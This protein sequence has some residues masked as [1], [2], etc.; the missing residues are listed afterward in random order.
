MRQEHSHTPLVSNELCDGIRPPRGGGRV[1][2][3]SNQMRYTRYACATWSKALGTTLGLILFFAC[4]ATA[5]DFR[6]KLTVTVND[7]SGLA[8]PGA[9]LELTNANSGELSSV[10]T[11]ETGAYSFLF[12][13][14]GSYNLKVSAAGFK[15]T[16]RD[17]IVLQSYQAS[18][19]EIRM[20]VGGV[21]D[22]VT[23]TDEG[24]LL[25]TETASRGMNVDSRL[26][27]DL[28]V[29]N[30]NAMMLGQTLAGVYMRP[31][32]AYT[33]PWTITSQFMIN[34]GLMYLNEFQ[35]DGAPNNAQFGNNVYGYNPPNEAVQEVSVQANS[36]DAQYGHTSGGVVNVSTKPGG[37]NFHG[38]AWTYLKR[39]G[40]NANSFQNNAIGAPRAPAPQ[41]QWGLQVSGPYNFPKI[42]PK[43]DRFKIFYLFSWDKYHE[44]LP[45]PLNLSYPA[46]EMRT[47]DFS[48]LTNGAGQPIVI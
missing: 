39:T 24:A 30:H 15:P 5:Q 22:A 45:N 19:L 34:G 13:L 21:T 48:K 16:V 6:A 23:V 43:S 8:V 27:T 31:L 10:K 2:F 36:Y 29:S 20:D 25:Q 14:P 1:L 17:N 12:L 3:R 35:V 37:T 33:D 44:Q 28:P 47:G 42:S 46:A 11:N 4:S 38:Q 41:S 40:W 18:G 9:T 32:G 7:P 26:V